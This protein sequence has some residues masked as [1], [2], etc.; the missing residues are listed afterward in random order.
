VRAGNSRAISLDENFGFEGEG[1]CRDAILD[2]GNSEDL[3]IMANVDRSRAL[4]D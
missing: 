2:E 1:A 4:L 3:I